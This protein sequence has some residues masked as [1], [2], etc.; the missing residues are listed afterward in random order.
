MST[1]AGQPRSL[2]R[3]IDAKLR[4]L[5]DSDELR[6]LRHRLK[7]ASYGGVP[8]AGLVGQRPQT[9][10]RQYD[11]T[12]RGALSFDEFRRLVRMGG[13]LAPDQISDATIRRIFRAVDTSN[14]GLVSLR[15]LTEL[16]W[17]SDST[18]ADSAAISNESV[19]VSAS[20]DEE[21]GGQSSVD[22][23]PDG[24]LAY[25]DAVDSRS[26][27]MLSEL[28]SLRD[29]LSVAERE[30]DEAVAAAATAIEIGSRTTA[31]AQQL[32][33]LLVAARRDGRDQCSKRVLHSA[34]LAWRL[35]IVSRSRAAAE[36]QCA[37]LES[38]FAE[39][40]RLQ[41]AHASSVATD[42][43][44]A[45]ASEAASIAAARSFEQQI[46]RLGEERA[47]LYADQEGACHAASVSQRQLSAGRALVVR[48]HPSVL[49]L[50]MAHRTHHSWS[51]TFS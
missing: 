24:D 3:G 26:Q 7:A 2:D 4:G 35:T 14:S 9:L 51:A 37:T 45:Q 8:S 32:E 46:K 18:T 48:T 17:D 42:L 36:A 12:S 5:L 44:K 28:A 41:Q 21:A 16:V 49:R 10:L 39:A 11:L 40:E 30:R 13:R 6:L 1:Q 27:Q 15:D 20:A 22:A 23:K 31:Q 25:G 33:K 29:A 38:Q 19:D 50:T 47:A 34:L 43:R